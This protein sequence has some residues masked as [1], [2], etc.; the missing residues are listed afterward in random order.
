MGRSRRRLG[1]L[2]RTPANAPVRPASDAGR[3][4]RRAKTGA[5]EARGSRLGRGGFDTGTAR[6]GSI[7]LMRAT[8]K[9]RPIA[10]K[11]TA[12]TPVSNPPLL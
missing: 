11:R 2:V 12:S 5:A 6:G 9:G 8:W 3:L 4:A 7:G 10:G 1:R